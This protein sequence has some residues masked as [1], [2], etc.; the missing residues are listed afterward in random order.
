MVS[1]RDVWCA[2]GRPRARRIMRSMESQDVKRSE[3]AVH[4]QRDEKKICCCG[5]S[6]GDAWRVV[7]I[8]GSGDERTD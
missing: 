1:W 3:R 4:M 6:V 7:L 5:G 2:T 8:D